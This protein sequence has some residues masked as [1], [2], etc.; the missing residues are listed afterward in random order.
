MFI[1]QQLANNKVSYV[2]ESV[3]ASFSARAANLP[4]RFVAEFFVF[5]TV[6]LNH[7]RILRELIVV[8]VY[9]FH[10]R[11]LFL[12]QPCLNQVNKISKTHGYY[13]HLHTYGIYWRQR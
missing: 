3:S 10:R 12:A 9:N 1:S 13:I 7:I 6:F 5:A 8:R 2:K 4:T 11:T